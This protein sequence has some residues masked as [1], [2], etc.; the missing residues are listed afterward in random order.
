MAVK[1]KT[2]SKKA[3][4]KKGPGP[5]KKA[6]TK[7]KA[8]PKKPSK[9]AEIEYNFDDD[10]DLEKLPESKV[11]VPT[12]SVH[13]TSE[14]PR[15]KLNYGGNAAFEEEITGVVAK[16]HFLRIYQAEYNP[17]EKGRPP[18]CVSDPAME[19]GTAHPSAETW[20]K[21]NGWTGECDGC[22]FAFAKKGCN[23]VRIV[24]L[25]RTDVEYE[26]GQVR[27]PVALRV[28]R[29]ANAGS[30]DCYEE[31]MEAATSDGSKPV[32]HEIQV[33][34]TTRYGDDGNSNPSLAFALIGRSDLREWGKHIHGYREELLEKAQQQFL[35][36]GGDGQKLLVG[37][38]PEGEE[39]EETFAS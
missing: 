8:A 26:E 34:A 15:V 24:H 6:T 31:V 17:D 5:K 10:E 21:E 36:S 39:E 19:K 3:S 32:H 33:S 35:P 22:P 18:I 30:D 38:V 28:T 2:A 4:K 25:Y 11:V 1:K 12:G 16:A 20:L 27:K 23:R 7:K 29:S 9:E 13:G 14:G 37:E